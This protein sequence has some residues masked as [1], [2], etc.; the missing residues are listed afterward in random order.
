VPSAFPADHWTPRMAK[1]F[2]DRAETTARVVV[3]SA[4]RRIGI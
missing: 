2:D 4:P 1:V 3:K